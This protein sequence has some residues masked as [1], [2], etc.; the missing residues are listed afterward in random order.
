MVHEPP[1]QPHINARNL[2][3]FVWKGHLHP[4]TL[5][6]LVHVAASCTR[7]ATGSRATEHRSVMG[8]TPACCRSQR[9]VVL[10]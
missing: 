9:N 2:M 5:V 4:S 6:M 8:A 1:F 10:L 3:C 7:A